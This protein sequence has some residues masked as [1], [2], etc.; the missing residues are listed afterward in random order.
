MTTL[1]PDKTVVFTSEGKEWTFYYGMAALRGFENDTGIAIEKAVSDGVSLE[2]CAKL[3]K[4]GLKSAHPDVT[5]EQVDTIFDF[6]GIKE[7]MLL[8]TSALYKAFPNLVAP[9][10]METPNEQDG[11]TS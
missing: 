10:T 4:Q 11:A 1:N 9:P 6:V 2:V 8:A 3:I 7:L 5:M